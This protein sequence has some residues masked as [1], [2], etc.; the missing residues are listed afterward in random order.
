MTE[1]EDTKNYYIELLLYQYI[2]QP[3]ARATI[4]ALVDVALCDLLPKSINDAFDLET[5]TGAQLDILGE[6]IGIQRAID[7]TID[8]GFFTFEDDQNPVTL[9]YG[10]T[11]YRDPG[12][13][14]DVLF[15]QYIDSSNVIN[16]L[17]DDEYRILLKLKSI[18]NRSNNSLYEINSILFELFGSD[19]LV[20]D[21]LDMTISYFVKTSIARII[22]IASEQKLLP[23][24]MAVGL[25][26]FAL[27]DPAKVWGFNDYRKDSIF[28][29]G[30]SDY[31]TG[32]V[33]AKLLNYNNKV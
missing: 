10:L 32:F 8:R 18:V 14:A 33:D 23:R 15:K 3:K 12:L 22:D 20:Y 17:D 31:V 25:N 26:V 13:N 27:D 6:Y 5:A 28:L 30:F 19:I 2:N 21:Q 29:V 16:T 24:P 9:L 7:T 11:D 4:G 1:L